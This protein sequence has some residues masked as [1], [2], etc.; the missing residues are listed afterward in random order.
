M[1]QGNNG[2]NGYHHGNEPPNIIRFPGNEP[3][4]PKKRVPMF[5]LPPF[6]K[7]LI[8][9]IIAIHF[10]VWG[11]SLINPGTEYLIYSYGGFVPASWSGSLPFMWWTP[12]TLISFSFLHGGWLHLGVNTLMMMA[13]G[14]GVEKWLGWKRMLILFAGSSIAAAFFQFIS[15]PNSPIA[16]IGASGAISGFFGAMILMMKQ[17]RA[18]GNSENSIMPF[19]LIWILTSVIFGMMGAPDGTPI[20]W[21]A[22]IGGFLSG[23]GITWLMIRKSR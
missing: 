15:A 8:G 2:T 17:Q 9:V 11:L 22:H 4:A 18:L 1:L 5:N 10:C 3:P 12:L 13:F 16:V 20:A 6:T 21:L 23:M 14:S 19:V 7:I